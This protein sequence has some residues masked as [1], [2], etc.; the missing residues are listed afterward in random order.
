MQRIKL[1]DLPINSS[2]TVCEIPF[3]SARINRI[4]SLGIT[5][6]AYIT[7]LFRS[8]FK[9]P[10]AYRVKDCVIALRSTDCDLIIVKP[11]GSDI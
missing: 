4:K 9:D 10:T 6:G 11:V 1:S 8:P 5:E 3:G 7:P 2:A